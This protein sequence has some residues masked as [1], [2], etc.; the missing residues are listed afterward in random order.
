MPGRSTRAV[1]AACCD[2]TERICSLERY[3]EDDEGGSMVMS[4]EGSR[5]CWA[6]CERTA[7]Y[8]SVSNSATFVSFHEA[9]HDH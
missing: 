1:V 9:L 3:G 5:L 4:A 2:I 6:I 8:P 7:Y